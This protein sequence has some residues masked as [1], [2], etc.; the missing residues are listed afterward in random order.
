MTITDCENIIKS[1]FEN[2][3]D[4]YEHL[5]NK[6]L[7]VNNSN[8]RIIP[9][10]IFYYGKEMILIE[11]ENT[12]RPVESISKYW[13][14]LKNTKWLNEKIKIKLFII[15]LNDAHKGI[16]DESV[17]IL[18]SELKLK[19]PENI[20]FYYIPWNKVS[21]IEIIKILSQITNNGIDF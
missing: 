15:G 16:R 20:D 4:K 8:Y 13:W 6:K 7:I 9:D 18:G 1:Y 12:K 5:H 10:D 3:F 11:Y 21:E 14:L 19:F 17:E 2:N